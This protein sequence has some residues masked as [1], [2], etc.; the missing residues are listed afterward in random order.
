MA[1]GG[2]REGA[3]RKP[4]VPNKFTAELKDAILQAAEQAG[5]DEGIVGY[6]KE[7][8]A[9]NPGPF[10]SLLGKVLPMQ[11]TGEGGAPLT[12]E[13]TRFAPPSS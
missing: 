3:G 2:K 12:I 13:I 10:L 5:G 9:K 8:A 6:L 1:H 11:V 7:Q 4:G